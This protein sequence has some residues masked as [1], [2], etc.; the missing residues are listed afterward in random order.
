MENQNGCL[1]ITSSL[2]RVKLVQVMDKII[3]EGNF[4][5]S[6]ETCLKQCLRFPCLGLNS[7]INSRSQIFYVDLVYKSKKPIGKKNIPE[8]GKSFLVGSLYRNP[9][10]RIEWV[11]RFEKIIDVVLKERKKLY[12]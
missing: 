9:I 3:N 11:D 8:K 6:V 4:R 12:Y 10:E 1:N 7:I 5:L 2:F